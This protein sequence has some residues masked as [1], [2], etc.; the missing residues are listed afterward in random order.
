MQNWGL[1]ELSNLKKNAYVSIF[2]IKLGCREANQ[3]RL[4]TKRV[5]RAALGRE[6]GVGAVWSGL[7]Q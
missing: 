1:S 2:G 7:L 6:A 4:F 5:S 3:E